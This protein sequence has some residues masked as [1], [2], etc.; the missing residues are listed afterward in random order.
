MARLPEGALMQRAATGLALRRAR[1]ARPRRTA[2]GCCC[3]SAPATTAA[4]R[5]TPG[6]CSP[7]AACTVEAVLLAPTRCT[8]TGSR[9]CGGAGGRVV[10]AVE[11]ARRPTWSSTGSSAS[12][13]AAGCAP[14]RPAARRPLAGRPVVAVDVPSGVDVDTGQRRGPAR[15]APT[16]TV[17]FGTHKVAHL[18]DPAAHGLRRRAPGR[19]R[20]G[21]AGPGRSTALQ[22]DDVRGLLPRPAPD[23][24]KYT[25][26]VVGVRA[27]SEQYPGAGVLCVSGAGAGLAGMVRYARRR[28]RPRPRDSTPRS[29]SARAGCRPGWSGPAAAPTPSRRWPTRWP[30]GCRSW[31]TPTALTH[32]DRPAR[33]A[34]AAHPARRRAGPDAR[35]RA[36][37]GRGRAAALRPRGGASGTTPWC[38]SRAGT[39]WSPARRARCGSRR[40]GRPGWRPPAPATC[41]PGCAG[42]CWRPGWTRSTPARSGSWLHGAAAVAGRRRRAGHGTGRRRGAAGGLLA[43][44]SLVTR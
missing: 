22:E 13:A 24:H 34:R 14:T 31:S 19:H 6:R 33:R 17:T 2:P 30:T 25:R 1:P 36:G 44:C 27:G 16:V 5:C 35:R 7:D 18:V 26:G 38:C 12:A 32:V 8:P 41:S 23:A 4:T 43:T 20:A 39:R 9:P 37:A 10:D 28:G 42:R 11:A 21:P 15:D 40:S 3:S 29:W